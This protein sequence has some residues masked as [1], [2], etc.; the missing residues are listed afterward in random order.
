MNI[1]TLA[2]LF[3][4]DSNY[5]RRTEEVKAKDNCFAIGGR[6]IPYFESTKGLPNWKALGID[7]VID[8][9][10]RGRKSRSTKSTIS[11]KM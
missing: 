3:E 1:S 6:D 2:T 9:P 7:V 11:P 10:G 5:G 4:V 8:C